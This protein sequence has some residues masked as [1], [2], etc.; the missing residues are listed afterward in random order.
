[1]KNHAFAVI[2]AALW[3]NASEFLRNEALFKSYWITHYASLGLAFPSR[4]VNGMVW[5]LWGLFLA[6]AV[7]ALTRR[8]SVLEAAGIAWLTAFVLMWM[9]IGNLGVLP[10]GLL[11]MAAPWSFAEC[12]VAAFIVTRIAT[13]T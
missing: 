2:A 3:I 4:P 12:L 8:Y 7:H 9:V 10:H 13:P 11:W 5:G 6:V 1:M